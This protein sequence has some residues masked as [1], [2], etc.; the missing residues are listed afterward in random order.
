MASRAMLGRLVLVAAG[1]E[2]SPNA[3][4]PH[5]IALTVRAVD[6]PMPGLYCPAFVGSEN[7]RLGKITEVI[8]PNPSPSP[9]CPLIE[10]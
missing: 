10:S 2:E 3:H 1:Q 4:H 7:Q 6:I 5:A 8:Q 9:P